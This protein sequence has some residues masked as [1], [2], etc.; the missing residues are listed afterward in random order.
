[1]VG[2]GHEYLDEDRPLSDPE[3]EVVEMLVREEFPGAGALREQLHGL[4]VAARCDTCSSVV[5]KT[6]GVPR[7]DV[8]E[9][10]PVEAHEAGPWYAGRVH[11]LLHVVDGAL[12]ELEVFREDGSLADVLPAADHLEVIVNL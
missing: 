2:V 11:V 1:M 8:R 6:T 3:L 12:D 9:R 7:A 10:V 5:F 4:R